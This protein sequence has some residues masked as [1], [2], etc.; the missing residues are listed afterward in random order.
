MKK[1]L[2]LL[3]TVLCISCNNND[4]NNPEST[5]LIVGTWTE[6]GYGTIS[7]TN[8]VEF[9]EYDYF[10][11]T[12]GRYVF[13]G[14]GTFR[15]ETFDGPDNNC[16]STGV[17]TGTW[18]KIG[19]TSY[20]ISILSDTSDDDPQTGREVTVRVEFPSNDRMQFIYEINQGGIAFEYDEYSRLN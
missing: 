12:L 11:A 18:E 5:D 19:N 13:N 16:T 15:V 4:N 6:I 17:V 7:D 8:D 1:A 2:L 20:L 9:F 14:D 3:F 10:C